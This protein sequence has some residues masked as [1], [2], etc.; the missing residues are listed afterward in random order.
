MAETLKER[1]I[2]SLA[3]IVMSEKLQS[4][5]SGKANQWRCFEC[6]NI[7]SL[8]VIWRDNKVAWMTPEMFIELLS[9]VNKRRSNKIET[10]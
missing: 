2:V 9:I 1:L 4:F 3:E 5:V 10:F 8:S 6:V 7:D